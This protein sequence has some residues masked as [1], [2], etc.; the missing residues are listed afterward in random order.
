M[1]NTKQIEEF[2]GLLQK[3]QNPL[4]L[5]DNDVD[6]LSSF[7]LL[8]RFCD[9]GKGV[10]IKSFPELNVAYIRKVHEFKPDYIFVLDKPLID[11]GFRDAARELNVPI[12]WLDH[13]PKPEYADEEGIL[14]FNPTAPAAAPPS[15]EPTA[16]WAYKITRKKEDEWIAM[17]GCLADWLIPEFAED[18]A[19]EYPDL[20]PATKNA[21][22][23]LY[24]TE[25]GRI[26]KMLSFALKDR[27]TI[28][29]KML[30]NLLTLKSPRELLEI[31]PKTI[32]IHKRY[33]QINRKYN[34]IISKAKEL[35]KP[36]KK[37]LFFQY[38]GDLSLS[39]ELA[40][41]LFYLYQDKI[42]VVAYIKGT[43]A[44]VSLRASI[45]IRDLAAKALEGIESTCGGH[46][47]ASGATLS[48]DDLPRFRNN[49]I[50]LV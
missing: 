50:K 46:E 27:T 6:G 17:I 39:S 25:L 33:E 36:N 47:K 24:E 37:I 10:A 8:A 23:A 22:K 43:K 40:N 38:R 13:H 3:A 48:A 4:F 2:R 20:F 7:L 45:N 49:L 26:I 18:F 9:K 19:R 28:V 30:K 35:A 34:K 15:S 1:L 29:V 31:S 44:N 41:E 14:Y 21:A 42:I 16:Y 32:S 11:K 5:F 12:V